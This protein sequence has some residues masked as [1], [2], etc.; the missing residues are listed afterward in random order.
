MGTTLF[1]VLDRYGP[2]TVAVPFQAVLFAFYGR[3]FLP[4]GGV[5][6][7]AGALVGVLW[8]LLLGRL[9]SWL[10]RREAW[11][12]LLANAPIMLGIVATG[13]MA[14]GGFT[15]AAMMG[16]VLRE[17]SLTYAVLSALMQP[18]VPYFIA[19][20]SAM[21]LVLVSWIIFGN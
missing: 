3:L 10:M 8:A 4:W 19:L 7:V 2:Y 16:E 6:T 1:S 14:G 18:A 15:H 5:A 13:L 11:H 21:E 12:D 17:P 9:A 20:N